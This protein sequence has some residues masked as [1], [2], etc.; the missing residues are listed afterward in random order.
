MS[1][2]QDLEAWSKNMPEIDHSNELLV[3]FKCAHD[4]VR[5]NGTIIPLKPL[6]DSSKNYPPIK[7]NWAD[8]KNL[9]AYTEFETKG[10]LLQAGWTKGYEDF[11]P[12]K[13]LL[14]HW[15]VV[16]VKR[17]SAEYKKTEW[18]PDTEWIPCEGKIV[19]K[20]ADLIY[21]GENRDIALMIMKRAYPNMLFSYD[22]QVAIVKYAIQNAY[23][24]SEQVSSSDFATQI[25]KSEAH[26]TARN[27]SKQFAKNTSEQRAMDSA[28]Q[29]AGAFSKQYAGTR[30]YQYA[31]FTSYQE[32]GDFSVQHIGSYSYQKGGHS[33]VLFAGL[34]SA[35]HCENYCKVN[36]EWHH[37][38]NSVI[39]TGEKSTIRLRESNN[40]RVVTAYD[41]LNPEYVHIFRQGKIMKSYKNS[42]DI[43]LGT[44]P[45]HIQGREF[46]VV[47]RTIRPHDP[48]KPVSLDNQTEGYNGCG[49]YGLVVR[50]E[51]GK[52]LITNSLLK[53]N[54]EKLFQTCIKHPDKI[55]LWYN[56]VE[57]CDFSRYPYELIYE[58]V[59][60]APVNLIKPKQYT[61]PL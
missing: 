32:A 42:D 9:E 40:K 12:E 51:N 53:E 37:F 36:A 48:K 52:K 14:G 47:V 34:D 35:Q 25:A 41:N 5:G 19:F 59:K 20:T 6:P 13:D 2:L 56:N 7:S 16:K 28:V 15:V 61:D 50:D 18:T 57:I 33:S 38:S 44:D 54:F 39:K 60:D 55:F 46:E 23:Y 11:I 43:L 45:V 8:T 26:Q 24:C 31:S 10:T 3:I 21:C 1:V 17:H 4:N 27:Y 30:A 22:K 29:I 49:L 58:I